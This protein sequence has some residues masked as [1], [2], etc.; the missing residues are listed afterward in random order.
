MRSS[1]RALFAG[2][3]AVGLLAMGASPALA[4]KGKAKESDDDSTV[5]AAAQG[6]N[7]GNGGNGGFGLNIC[8][9]IGILAKAEARCGAGN[10]GSANGGDAWAEAEDDSRD[11]ESDD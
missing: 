11:T 4:A 8:P 5:T 6:G 9:A 3:A 2:V 10:G 1:T 7:G